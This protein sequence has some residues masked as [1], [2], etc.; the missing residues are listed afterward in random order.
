MDPEKITVRPAEAKDCAQVWPLV[1]DFAVSYRPEIAAFQRTFDA[2]LDRPDTL[3]AL[4]EEDGERIV[5]Y[6]LASHHGT[7]HANGPVAWVE[8]LMVA[9][10]ARRSGLGRSLVAEAEGWARSIPVAYIALASRRAGEFYKKLDY[11]VSATY[12]K[13]GFD[14]PDVEV[15]VSE[16]G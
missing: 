12:F 9:E 4:A 10:S 6:V 2:L 13:K 7:F 16:A 15:H 11:H 3:V 8:E 14:P 1:R 5:G